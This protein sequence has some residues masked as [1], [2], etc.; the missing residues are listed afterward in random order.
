M[1]QMNQYGISGYSMMITRLETL[2]DGDFAVT[3]ERVVAS[4]GGYNKGSYVSLTLAKGEGDGKTEYKADTLFRT[5]AT[6]PWTYVVREYDDNK[7][8]TSTTY[9]E[10]MLTEKTAG[11]GE[12]GL[13][14]FASVKV[15]EK[16]MHTYYT[17]SGKNDGKSF[18]DIGADGVKLLALNGKGTW[19]A[20]GGV[21]S[22]GGALGCGIKLHDMTGR[23]PAVSLSWPDE[24]LL[25]AQWCGDKL[26]A[27]TDR[28]A[29]VIS[30]DGTVLYE[31]RFAETPTAMAIGEGGTLYTACG[32]SREAAGV[33]VTAYDATLAAVG[34]KTVAE[35]VLSLHTE[36][37]R[38]L[39]LTENT[40]LLG[41]A[42]L[43]EVSDRE[44]SG[45]QQ[46]APWQ[47]GYYCI[48]EEGL[49]HRR[50]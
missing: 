20:A 5:G 28:G 25:K 34:T 4:E 38:V 26:L 44:E 15:T 49:T 27:V 46:M 17:E 14:F 39:I 19:L 36:K 13:K 24:I 47:N 29:R 2:K 6:E 18:V 42:A 37:N 23:Q 50:L 48:T 7:R 21:T 8:I 3:A 22:G 1:Q 32:D 45:I 31:A 40:L 30:T 41:D 10:I 33:T 9:F 11:V 43:T 12:T 16:A 35:R